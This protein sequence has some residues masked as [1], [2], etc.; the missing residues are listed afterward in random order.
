MEV[1]PF[2]LELNPEFSLIRASALTKG[3]V[4]VMKQQ[5]MF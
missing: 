4:L 2:Y 3:A 5:A 1:Q